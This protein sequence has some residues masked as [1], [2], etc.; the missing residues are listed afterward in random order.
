LPLNQYDIGL[1]AERMMDED[2]VTGLVNP[3]IKLAAAQS[4]RDKARAA[5]WDLDAAV[6]LFA[7]LI[8]VI[9][10]LFQEIGSEI[11][12]PVAVFGLAIVWLLGWRRE[13]QLYRRYYNQELLKLG[14]ELKKTEDR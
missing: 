13:R 9:I 12:V 7:I 1:Q 10:L 5:R 3:E 2:D 14:R 6:F 8:I 11:V 4:A